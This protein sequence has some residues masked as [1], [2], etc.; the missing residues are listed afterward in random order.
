TAGGTTLHWL[1]TCLRMLPEDFKVRTLYGQGLDW[2]LNYEELMPYYDL[3]EHEIGVSAD[4]NEQQYLGI[5]FNP[6]YV[7]P[8]FKVPQS[9]LDKTLAHAVK[10]MT[11]NLDG[12][13]YP[14]TVTS[15]P[16]GRNSMPNPAYEGGKGYTPI[17]ATYNPDLGQRCAGNTSCVPICPIQ[18]KYNALKT[19]TRTNAKN[20]DILTQAVASQVLFDKATGEITGI[21][22]KAYPDQRSPVYQTRV[23]KGTVYVLAA[24]AVENAKLLLA[25]GVKSESGLI[26]KNLMDHPV[27]ITWGLTPEKV[28]GFRGP[29][30]TSGIES[31][32]GGSFRSKRAA[33]RIEIGNEGWNWA[34]GAPYT[35]LINLVD[36]M[37]SFGRQLMASVNDSFTRQ[38][39]FGFLVE[40]LP[41]MSNMITIDP[42]Y[43]DQIGN[44]RPVIY[45]NLSDYVRAGA[46]SGLRV[47]DLI[48]QRIGARNFTQYDPSDGGYYTYLGQGYVFNGA[49]HFA[50]THVMGTGKSN[51]VVNRDQKS[52]E[53]KNLYLVGCGSFPNM[54]TSNPTLTMT[55]LTFMAAEAIMRDL[56]R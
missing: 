30:S 37:N 22:Y 28:W 56:K 45:Y 50:G 38:F 49:G 7:Y 41:E 4:V 5:H 34:A 32:R 31:L 48:Y 11:V 13:T 51:S 12:Q 1:G 35:Q 17:G 52:W 42:A 6:G 24:H 14:I 16:Q 40:Q 15:T 21:E 20:V 29:L 47:S 23:A 10:G 9:Y 8:M 33:Y 55:A 54:G 39:R 3:A 43:K 53:H 46:A 36:N 26:G 27:L 18:A 25:S 44:Y 2:P 19:L